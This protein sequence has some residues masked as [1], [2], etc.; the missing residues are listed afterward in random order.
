LFPS[1]ITKNK[2]SLAI[3]GLIWMGEKNFMISQ[4]K[5]KINAGF[6]CIKIKIGSLDFKTELDIIKNIRKEYSLKN[7]EIRVDANCAFTFSEAL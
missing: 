2:D 1:A 5:E 6:D 4:I 7:L 3:N